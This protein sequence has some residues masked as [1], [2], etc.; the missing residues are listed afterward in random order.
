MLPV[1]IASVSSLNFW[2]REGNTLNPFKLIVLEPVEK[3]CHIHGTYLAKRV[4]LNILTNNV[5]EELCPMCEKDYLEFERAE[6][7]KKKIQS[8]NIP[9][10]YESKTL[11]TFDTKES[12]KLTSAKE[13]ARRYMQSTTP[14]RSIVFVGPTNSGKTHLACAVLQGIAD[15]TSKHYTN[16]I[17][18]LDTIK[19]SY[20]NK[21]SYT[22]ERTEF[23]VSRYVRYDY[24]VI[25]NFEEFSGTADNKAKLFTLI[26]ERYNYKKSTIICATMTLN[27]F[28][29][30]YDQKIIRRL[31][32]KGAIVEL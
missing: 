22:E 9:T 28:L 15:D 10:Y 2:K 11:D 5:I 29:E 24:L 30:T 27:Q 26:N 6:A 16:I 17:T 18:I 31:K 19:S 8:Y 4:K 32:E 3:V 25:D 1:K 23:I 7:R 14:G 12:Q 21:R 20:S 13:M